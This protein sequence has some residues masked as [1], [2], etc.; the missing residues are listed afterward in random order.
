MSDYKV[1]FIILNYKTKHLLRLV[2]KN[3]RQLELTVPYEVIV[4]DNAS[5][6]GSVE[7]MQ[8]LYPD[9]KLINSPANSGHACGNNLGIQEARG[10]YLV[11]MNSDIIF[12][13]QGDVVKML[14]YL[15]EHPEVALLGPRLMNGDGSVQNSCFRPYSTFTPLFRRTPL[16]RLKYAQRDLA[17]HLMHDFD[18]NKL[19]E[20]EWVLGAVVVAR[21]AVFDQIG[22]FDES[23]FLYYAD[24]ELCDRVRF[25]GHKIIYYPDVNIVHYHRRQSAEGSIWGGLGSLFNYTTRVHLKEW[26]KYRKIVKRY[27][28]DS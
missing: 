2:V 14:T 22:P 13:D 8:E 12:F 23:F 20:V 10:E 3:L 18:H 7:M 9:V 11:I 27:A 5:H 15:D 21:R 24:F 1:S 19:Q 28:A 26:L 6:D 16:G 4:I 17:R 25:H